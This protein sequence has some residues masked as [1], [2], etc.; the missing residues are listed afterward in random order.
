[1]SKST[2]GGL[3]AQSCDKQ[4][5]SAAGSTD[6]TPFHKP[7]LSY[8]VPVPARPSVGAACSAR[9]E[10]RVRVALAHTQLMQ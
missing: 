1:M 6:V 2:A 4:K 3:H 10:E 9:V 5:T 7:W 8:A